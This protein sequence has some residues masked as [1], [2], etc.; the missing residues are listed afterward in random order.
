VLTVIPIDVRLNEG[1]AREEEGW[2]AGLKGK[3]I[4]E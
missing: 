2:I 4:H 1:I 3:S